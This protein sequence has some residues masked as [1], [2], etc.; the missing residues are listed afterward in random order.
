MEYG[1]TINRDA[2]TV[3]GFQQLA[4][5]VAYLSA[6]AMSATIYIAQ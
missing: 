1:M 6:E 4:F 2:D 5:G 3:A